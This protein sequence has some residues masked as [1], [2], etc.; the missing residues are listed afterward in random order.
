MNNKILKYLSQF[1][2]IY[3]SLVFS[4]I[5]II[6]ILIYNLKKQLDLEFIDYFQISFFIN[7][8]FLLPLFLFTNIVTNTKSFKKFKFNY[9]FIF[10]SVFI[11]NIITFTFENFNVSILPKN[12]QDNLVISYIFIIIIQL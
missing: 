10:I 12:Y 3:T 8:I 5:F 2:M 11:V 6:F 9:I 4:Y 1:G 7:L